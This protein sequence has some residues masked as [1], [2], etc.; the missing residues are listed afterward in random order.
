MQAD[1]QRVMQLVT[2]TNCTDPKLRPIKGKSN[3]YD[4]TEDRKA[5]PATP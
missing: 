4:V 5:E 1:P 3:S 2:K